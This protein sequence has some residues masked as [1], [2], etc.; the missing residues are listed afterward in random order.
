[1]K[2][3]PTFHVSQIKPVHTSD[4]CPPTIPPPP[5]RVIDDHP[6]YTV[7][8]LMDV[9]RRGRGFQYLV[10]WEGYNL[11]ERCW[12]PRSRIMDPVMRD[13]EGIQLMYSF[14]IPYLIFPIIGLYG[15]CKMK[16]WAL[17]VSAVG[18]I[19]GSLVSMAFGFRLLAVRPWFE[20]CG[21]DQGYQD[22]GDNIPDS[23]LCTEEST[24]PCVAAPRNSSLFEYNDDDKP[25]KIYQEIFSTVLC[26][27]ILCQLKN[28]VPAVVYSPEAR[29]VNIPGYGAD[30]TCWD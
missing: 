26:I 12:V 28:K 29:N 6:A 30:Y 16:K 5:P 18:M 14:S 2:I 8:R 17:I 11:E 3:H 20:C 25:I 15:T 13:H 22:W 9:R 23:C 10:D 1:M 4:L 27:L 24:N 21:L 19:L 7:R